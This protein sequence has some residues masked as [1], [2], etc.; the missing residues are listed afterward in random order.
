MDRILKN[1]L[2]KFLKVLHLIILKT[3]EDN[4]RRGLRVPAAKKKKELL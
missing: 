2:D 4:P 1:P 3:Q